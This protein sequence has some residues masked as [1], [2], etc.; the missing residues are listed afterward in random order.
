MISEDRGIRGSGYQGI[1]MS[2]KTCSRCGVN[3]LIRSVSRG[4]GT[5]RRQ[6][7]EDRQIEY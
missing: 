4:F 2:R 7:T 1:N 3:S 5:I 6:K